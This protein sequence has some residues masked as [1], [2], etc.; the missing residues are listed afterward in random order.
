[1]TTIIK[2]CDRCKQEVKWLYKFPV[3]TV[4]GLELDVRGNAELCVDCTRALI[5]K[6]H[7][8]VNNYDPSTENH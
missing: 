2:T 1:M 4:C 3:F 5:L 8:E 6:I 7:Q